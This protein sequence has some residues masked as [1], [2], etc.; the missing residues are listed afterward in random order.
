[1]NR[2]MLHFHPKGGVAN[3]FGRRL[4]S[5]EVIQR[6]D[7]HPTALIWE[8]VPEQLVGT[9]VK[10]NLST[11]IV[12]PAKERKRPELPPEKMGDGSHLFL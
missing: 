11:V 12:H 5:K 6:G 4:G 8:V 9:A 1:M 3:V 2:N 7:F 10:K